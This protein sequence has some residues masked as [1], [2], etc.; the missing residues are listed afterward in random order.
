M[1]S[2]TPGPTRSLRGHSIAA[3]Q[4]SPFGPRGRWWLA[5]TVL[6]LALALLA[7][8]SIWHPGYILQ[9]DT[10]WGPRAAPVVPGFYAPIAWLQNLAVQLAGGAIVGRVYVVAVLFAS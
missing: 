7:A 2:L 10:V 6:A 8:R 5:P 3:M 1:E 4:D 9:V